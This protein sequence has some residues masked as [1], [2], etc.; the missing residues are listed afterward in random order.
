[1]MLGLGQSTPCPAG[2]AAVGASCAVNVTGC[3]YGQAIQYVPTSDTRVV[4]GNIATCVSNGTPTMNIFTYPAYLLGQ[5]FPSLAS[6][7]AGGLG[8]NDLGLS[9]GL[10]LALGLLV[11]SMAKK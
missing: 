1:M 9:V 2:T 8:L 6:W 10:W 4:G 11:F 7:E 3:P 5:A